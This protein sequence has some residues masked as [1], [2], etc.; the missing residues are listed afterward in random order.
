MW[1]ENG[2]P[3]P[4]DVCPACKLLQFEQQRKIQTRWPHP[5]RLTGDEGP[6]LEAAEE[7]E[8]LD[9]LDKDEG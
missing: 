8:D 4:N 7:Y 9:D 1:V 2:R 5:V 6:P 3:Q